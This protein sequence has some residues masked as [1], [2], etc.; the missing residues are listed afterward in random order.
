MVDPVPASYGRGRLTIKNGQSLSLS[1]FLR[2]ALKEDG[3][4]PRTQSSERGSNSRGVKLII[5]R[6]I[7]KVVMKNHMTTTYSYIRAENSSTRFTNILCEFYKMLWYGSSLFILIQ[8]G[9]L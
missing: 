1:H 6:N 7:L 4:V 3:L 2:L 9:K 8:F 5:F